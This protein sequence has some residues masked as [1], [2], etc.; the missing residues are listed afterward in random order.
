MT[1]KIRFNI[2]YSYKDSSLNGEDGVYRIANNKQNMVGFNTDHHAIKAFLE[3][4]K[5]S[6]A[7]L[8]VYDKECGR[9]LMWSI[10]NRKKP[11]S[12]MNRDDFNAYIEF[13]R[14]P[15]TDWCGPKSNKDNEA[16]RPFVGPLS[17]SA[18][19]TAIAAINSLMSWLV[20]AGYVS[21]NPMGLIRNKKNKNRGNSPAKKV[22][23]FLDED[24]WSA[25]LLTVENLPVESAS[26]VHQKERM[27][28]MLTF[29]SL[30]GARV[31][32][33][34][35]AQMKDFKNNVAGWFWEVTGKGE[36][37]ANVAM[38][39]D[40]VDALMRWR[41]FLGLSP[42]P[43]AGE[44]TAVMPS[45]NKSYRPMLSKSGLTPRRVNQI[46]KDFFNLAAENL[47][48]NEQEDKAEKIK[49]ASAHWLRHTSITQKVNAGIDRHLVQVEARHSDARTTDM[50]THDEE[51]LR[52]EESQKHRI[53]W[54]E[55]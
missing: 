35:N 37:E 31:S 16:W 55:K 6:P 32:E 12:S 7:T 13:L 22:E 50:Y 53:G 10:L 41:K 45:V 49:L 18:V 36:K 17:E 5:D 42:L 38:P 48:K 27:R 34:S 47:I 52:A 44:I 43:K 11:L 26:E 4:Y 28:F 21:G 1:S 39:K 2:E 19:K 9:L 23:R 51:K 33:L 20:N 3:E 15:D 14:S 29:F 46:L 24:M 25:L 54:I 30:L 8:R 40:M